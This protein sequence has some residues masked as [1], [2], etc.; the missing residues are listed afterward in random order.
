VSGPVAEAMAVGARRR[1]GAD[2]AVAVTGVAGPSGGTDAKP[3]GLVYLAV[4]T[5]V[6]TRAVEQRF[7][8]TPG[9]DGIRHLAT[10]A[11]LNLIRLAVQRG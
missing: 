3:V 4:A 10:Q 11:A 6:S 9:R 1:A 5:P 8:S 2:V 7:G